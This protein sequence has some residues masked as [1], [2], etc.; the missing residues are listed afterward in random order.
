M[1]S[2]PK[3]ASHRSRPHRTVVRVAPKPLKRWSI[4]EAPGGLIYVGTFRARD[5]DG[6]V[7]LYQGRIVER[8]NL[9]TDI[10]I[11]S[12]PLDLKRHEHGGCFQLLEPGSNWFK[13]HWD[14]P[15]SDFYTSLCY[16]EKLLTEACCLP[17]DTSI[18]DHRDI[19]DSRLDGSLSARRVPGFCRRILD[20]LLGQGV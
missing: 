17:E 15:T 11:L 7:H 20:W 1:N 16:V 5:T 19:P 14:H 13:M 8:T 10:Y 18:D 4:E 3:R 2:K 9:P 12:P 6:H